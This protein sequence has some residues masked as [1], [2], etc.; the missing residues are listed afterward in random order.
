MGIGSKHKVKL[1]MMSKS[2]IKMCVYSFNSGL[3]L[4]VKVPVYTVLGKVTETVGRA[5]SGTES[6]ALYENRFS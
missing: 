1:V 5:F 2:I 6:S 3:T 4:A